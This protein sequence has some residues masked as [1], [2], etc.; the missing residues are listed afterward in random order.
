M[1]KRFKKAAKCECA[2]EGHVVG[3]DEDRRSIVAAPNS[4][5][6]NRYSSFVACPF[7]QHRLRVFQERRERLHDPG[8]DLD[9]ELD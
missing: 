1:Q 6:T 4:R 3:G 9:P 7:R 8:S 2:V 5:R